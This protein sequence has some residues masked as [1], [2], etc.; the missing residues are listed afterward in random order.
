MNTISRFALEQHGGPYETWPLR[1]R[2][3]LNGEP[4]ELSVPGYVL[5]H[6]FETEAGFVLVTDCD[7]LFEEFTHFILLSPQLRL[8]SCRW[9][10][11]INATF[12]LERI[13]WI[14]ER[15]FIA[16]IYHECCYRFTIRSWGIPYI[17]PRLGMKFLGQA[18]CDDGPEPNQ[19]EP[20]AV[21]RAA[22]E[23]R[24]DD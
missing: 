6:Q 18:A 8:L 19:N 2:L 3:F 10:G 5:L 9:L 15:T 14:D 22:Y 21:G 23:V 16:V 1:S 4:T 17:R 12:L 24:R 13:E 20:G 7:C 11:W